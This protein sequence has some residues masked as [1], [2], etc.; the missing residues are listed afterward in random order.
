[1]VE[2]QGWGEIKDGL[3]APIRKVLADRRGRPT[4]VRMASG[5]E[6]VVYDGTGWGR[7]HGDLWEHVLVRTT[8]PAEPQHDFDSDLIWFSEVESLLEPE[9]REVMIVQT[10]APGER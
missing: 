7:D 4:I 6:I 5:E 1:M 8:P 2:R 3:G 10:P 9:N